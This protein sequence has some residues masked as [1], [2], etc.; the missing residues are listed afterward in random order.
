MA[1]RGGKVKS[2]TGLKTSLKKGGGNGQYLKRIPADDALTVRFLTEPTEWVTFYEHYDAVK[3]F[4]PC[5][6]DCSGCTEGEKPSARYLAN[7]L[8]VS[9]TKV[10]PLVMPKTV[11]ASLLKKYDKYA[12]LLDRDYELSR[13]GTGLE[14]EYDVTPESPTK[15]N[16][17]RFDLLDLMETL[18]AQL[19]MSENTSDDDEDEDEEE[20]VVKKSPARGKAKAPARTVTKKAKAVVEDDE[21]EDDDEEDA[22]E[23][24]ADASEGAGNTR[25]ELLSMSLSELKALAREEYQ[26]VP[27]DMRGKDKDAIADLILGAAPEAD[28][29]EDEDDADDDES[30]LTEDQI[31]AMPLPELKALAKELGIRVKVGTSKDDI[32]ELILDA[33]DEAEEEIPF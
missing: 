6:D 28:E 3:K 18:E 10:V 12:T 33:A 2:I 8:D 29:D 31:R 22:D 1:I 9:E 30:D 24:D 26:I 17:S 4:Y 20:E 27:A 32:I 16:I 5:T 11:A 19:E 15:M 7:A 23:D 21:D 14:T 13:S 25:E